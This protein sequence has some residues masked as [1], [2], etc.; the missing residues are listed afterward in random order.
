MKHL[1]RIISVSLVLAIT[2]VIGIIVF[3]AGHPQANA[4]NTEFYLLGINGKAE[5]Y[6]AAFALD[7]QPTA[8]GAALNVVS[9]QYDGQSQPVNE[10]YG[11]VTL[12]IVN[13]EQKTATYKVI[14]KIDGVATD[15]L[16]P[17]A[18]VAQLDVNLESEGKWE[19]LLGVEPQKAGA[20]QKVEFLL[21]KDGGDIPYRNLYFWTDV[22]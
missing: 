12:G 14:M 22:Q 9:V 11:R 7:S 5:N 6:P 4:R 3:I 8:P 13:H 15:M 10:K 16:I 2:A 19:Q 17:G 20:H 21:Y 18:K 1:R